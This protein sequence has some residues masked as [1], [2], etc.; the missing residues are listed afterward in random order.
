MNQL[1]QKL[2]SGRKR[3]MRKKLR[4]QLSKRLWKKQREKHRKLE[5]IRPENL[6]QKSKNCNRD[7][8]PLAPAKLSSKLTKSKSMLL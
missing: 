8:P 5:K 7:P 6:E 1:P 3:Q 2:P 4:Q